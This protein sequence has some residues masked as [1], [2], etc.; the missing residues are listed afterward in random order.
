M[1][2]KEKIL[3]AAIHFYDGKKHP[4][5]PVETGI[6]MCGK[7]HAHIFS[8]IAAFVGNVRERRE[9]GWN[10]VE[11]GFLTTKNRFVDRVEG[12]SIAIQAGQIAEDYPNNFLYSEFINF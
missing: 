11:Q 10:E 9:E 3:C 7:T 4:H 2:G 6:V 1:E 12:K 8:Q 5:Q